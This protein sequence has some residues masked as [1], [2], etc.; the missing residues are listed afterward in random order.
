MSTTSAEVLCDSVSRPTISLPIPSGPL[1][2]QRAIGA[3]SSPEINLPDCSPDYFDRVR[4]P[5]TLTI[6]AVVVALRESLPASVQPYIKFIPRKDRFGK[7]FTLFLKDETDA[8]YEEERPLSA[9]SVCQELAWEYIACVYICQK[10]CGKARPNISRISPDQHV[11]FL[12]TT[13]HMSAVNRALSA[14]V[15]A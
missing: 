8:C 1:V 13:Q 7:T 4:P 2:R 9:V 14:C 11:L 6:S 10:I 5:T 3:L 12:K 15:L